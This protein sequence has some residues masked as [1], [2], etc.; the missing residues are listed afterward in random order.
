[1][2]I[3]Q[4]CHKNFHYCQLLATELPIKILSKNQSCHLLKLNK[5][6][7]FSSSVIFS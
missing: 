2:L 7:N 1:M 3:K 5:N 6:V 4:E